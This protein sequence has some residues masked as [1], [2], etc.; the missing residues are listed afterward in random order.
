MLAT[1]V[2]LQ[3]FIL[4]Y[5]SVTSTCTNSYRTLSWGRL[6]YGTQFYLALSR[7][8]HKVRQHLLIRAFRD[9]LEQ[10]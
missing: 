6:S 4:Q 10:K 9:D 2:E 8:L 7:R 3:N 1:L 5:Q